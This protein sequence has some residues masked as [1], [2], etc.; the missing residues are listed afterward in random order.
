[1]AARNEGEGIVANANGKL[2]NWLI[3]TGDK[4]GKGDILGYYEIK[5]NDIAQMKQIVCD[6]EEDSII[7]KIMVGQEEDFNVGQM[8]L[9][10]HQLERLIISSKVTGKL[11]NLYVKEG[12]VVSSGQLLALIQP[13]D[14]SISAKYKRM[15]SPSCCRIE[16][17]LRHL[18]EELPAKTPVIQ[19]VVEECKHSTIIRDMCATCG[20]DLSKSKS[21]RH[22]V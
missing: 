7:K 5:L 15:R 20:K 18:G 12:E 17:I 9:E 21:K 19:L 8:L 4:I 11:T 10:I 13:S 3:N 14:K 2:I 6:K 16:K 1:M 22:V